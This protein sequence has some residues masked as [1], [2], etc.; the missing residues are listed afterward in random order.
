MTQK[1]HENFS[2][3]ICTFSNQSDKIKQNDDIDYLSYDEI[4]D[5][6]NIVGLQKL[7]RFKY[8]KKNK[9]IPDSNEDFQ[10]LLKIWEVGNERER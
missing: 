3:W 6:V 9:Y 5:I 10:L 1:S 8:E 7:E 2:S 4:K